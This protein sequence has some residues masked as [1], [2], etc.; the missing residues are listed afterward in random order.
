MNFFCIS[1]PKKLRNDTG[2]L[3]S[4]ER[5]YF[6]CWPRCWVWLEVVV[7]LAPSLP[8]RSRLPTY[9]SLWLPSTHWYS[10]RSATRVPTD[11]RSNVFFSVFKPKQNEVKKYF[12]LFRFWRLL[13]RNWWPRQGP[14]QGEF[15]IYLGTYILAS[16]CTVRYLVGTVPN[17]LISSMIRWL[18]CFGSSFMLCESRI[19]IRLQ[20]FLYKLF[21]RLSITL[22]RDGVLF[23]FL[24]NPSMKIYVV[25][26]RPIHWCK[27]SPPLVFS[28]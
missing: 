2:E 23:M 17:S 14:A 24:S 27:A 5:F 20:N 7:S 25:L 22:L 11:S 21:K 18:Q 9:P 15:F 10:H 16:N 19:Q 4:C 13:I 6:R 12:L 28:D 26:G 8:R 1:L 3:W